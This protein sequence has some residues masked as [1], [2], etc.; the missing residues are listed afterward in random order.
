MKKNEETD[1]NSKVKKLHVSHTDRLILVFSKVE[2]KVTSFD[3]F[4]DFHPLKSPTKL[5][6]VS[7]IHS[8]FSEKS[9]SNF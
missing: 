6:Y 9:K 2:L 4:D 1:E 7:N 5:I 3:I 8:L